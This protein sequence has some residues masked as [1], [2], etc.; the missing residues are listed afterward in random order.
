MHA[1][2]AFTPKGQ[3]LLQAPQCRTSVRMS[4]QPSPHSIP[5]S[6]HALISTSCVTG[7]SC[8]IEALSRDRSSAETSR[9][10]PSI[11]RGASLSRSMTPT[12]AIT[13]AVA[14]SIA[15]GPRS[16]LASTTFAASINPESVP[17][18]GLSVAC[19]A[20]ASSHRPVLAEHRWSALHST[21]RHAAARSIGSS[22]VC[23]SRNRTTARWETRAVVVVHP[24]GS[25]HPRAS[26]HTGVSMSS[27]DSMSPT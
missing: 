23:P 10:P 14:A 18:K 27:S 12:S 6:A 3:R 15:S 24:L 2:L 20:V 11:G 25:P 9:V 8:G 21:S 26:T 5:P 1:A 7:A 19:A 4:R 17:W 22:S 13:S 16:L